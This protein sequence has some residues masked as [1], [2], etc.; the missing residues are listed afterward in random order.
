MLCHKSFIPQGSKIKAFTL[1]EL[2]IVVAIIAILAAIAVP[3]FLEAQT[4]A[5]VSRVMNDHRAISLAVES[6]RVDHNREPPTRSEF[7]DYG[8]DISNIPNGIEYILMTSPIAYVS[9]SV[10]NDPF[11]KFGTLRAQGLA[12]NLNQYEYTTMNRQGA[13]ARRA[14]GM[15]YRYAMISVGPTA[16]KVDSANPGGNVVL[17]QVLT[18]NAPLFVYD[19]SNGTVSEGYIWRTNKGLYTGEDYP[20][21]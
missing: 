6:Y 10:F 4:R 21:R 14:Q 2:L 18:G 9:D 20:N 3:N 19:P 5:K 8:V 13:P 15:G 17:T 7:A 12:S 16:S 11:V 1:I